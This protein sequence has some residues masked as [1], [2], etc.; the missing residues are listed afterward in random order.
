LRRLEIQGGGEDGT[1]QRQTISRVVTM[2][3]N[4]VGIGNWELG[5]GN[6][7]LGEAG[8]DGDDGDEDEDDD[9]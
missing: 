2:T 9:G 6:W 7:E 3:D 8:G 1:Q 5:I 4:D